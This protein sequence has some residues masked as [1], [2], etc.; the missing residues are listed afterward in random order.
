MR[1]HLMILGIC[2]IFSTINAQENRGIQI[3]QTVDD[4]SGK[5]R[6]A[7]VIG[8]G[9]YSNSPLL[10]PV[11]DATDFASTLRNLGFEVQLGINQRRTELRSSIRT[12]GD[13]LRAT[14]GV[15]LF[16]YAGHGIQV[17]G[18]NY[19]IPIGTTV[20]REYEVED[21]CVSADLI[22]RS[23]EDASN[24]LNIVIL[25]ACRNNP[26]ARSWRSA[27]NGLARMAAPS[28]TMIIYSTKP[29]MIAQDGTTRNSPFT[30]HLL[31]LVNVSGLEIGFLVRELASNLENE[32]G[33]QQSPWMEG[34][35]KG[36]FYFRTTLTNDEQK[37]VDWQQEMMRIYQRA[38]SLDSD[39]NLNSATKMKIW[40]AFL[41]TYADNNPYSNED[42]NIRSK[43]RGRKNHWVNYMLPVT[44]P[45]PVTSNDMVFVPSG[46][47]MMGRN[48]SDDDEK[49]IHLVYLDGFYMDKYEVTVAQFRDFCSATGHQ[50]PDQPYWNKD[51][52]PIVNV[53]CHDAAAYTK[54]A[55]KRLPT[56]AEWEYAAREGGKDVLFGNGK[57]FADPVEI[58]FDGRSKYEKSYSVSGVYRKRTT[59]VGSFAPNALGLYDMSGNVWEWCADWYDKNY[60]D[61]SPERNPQGPSSKRFRVLRGGSW[62]SEPGNV[63]CTFR[64]WNDP[65]DRDD[66]IGFRCVRSK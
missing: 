20:Y 53:T 25:D 61:N 58:N 16:F 34:M 38:D 47:F 29:G 13:R 9:G 11:N 3:R 22:L 41:S 45:S 15:G 14:Q 37:W 1:R 8:N 51:N 2:C 43:A 42:E 62:Y 4:M 63:R 65:D 64:Y 33:G 24:A 55:G 35:L 30:R 12:F 31:N 21:E 48:E 7:L 52:H 40:N 59:S 46:S 6:V 50:M 60:Y 39:A 10:N 26:Y 28:G 44:T 19:L 18:K 36:R 54:W 23:M 56:E 27:G 66:P 5:K 32:T 17:N 49:P 57:D